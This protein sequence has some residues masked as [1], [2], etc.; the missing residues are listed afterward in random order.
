MATTSPTGTSTNLVT[1]A[2]LDQIAAVINANARFRAGLSSAYEVGSIGCAIRQVE[3]NPTTYELD[4]WFPHGSGGGKA[5]PFTVLHGVASPRRQA[6]ESD[7]WRPPGGANCTIHP[8]GKI[9]VP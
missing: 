1:T 8:S 3:S 6:S 7:T 4:E 9:S 2:A 5:N